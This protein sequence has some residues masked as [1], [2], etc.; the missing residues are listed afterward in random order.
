M[1]VAV[2]ASPGQALRQRD[3]KWSLPGYRIFQ[4]AASEFEVNKSDTGHVLFMVSPIEMDFYQGFHSG[5]ANPLNFFQCDW[6]CHVIRVVPVPIC[7]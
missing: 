6:W 4:R 5:D 1:T 3:P 7:C 2:Y